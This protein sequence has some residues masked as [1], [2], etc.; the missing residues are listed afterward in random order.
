MSIFKDFPDKDPLEEVPLAIDFIDVL[1]SG[2]TIVSAG[3]LVTCQGALS[4]SLTLVHSADITQDPVVTQVVSA[5]IAGKTYLHRC[6]I[7][8]ST[9]R[10]L[11]G[12]GVQRCVLGSAG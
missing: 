10:T 5:G 11:V 1:E 9:N 12:A 3:W 4:N 6:V 2:E 8:T 7:V